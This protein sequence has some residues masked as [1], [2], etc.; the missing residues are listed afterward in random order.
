MNIVELLTEVDILWTRCRTFKFTH[1]A[2][3][4][5][6]AIVFSLLR[7]MS[8]LVV[9]FTTQWSLE[10]ELSAIATSSQSSKRATQ[11]IIPIGMFCGGDISLKSDPAFSFPQR[12][13][14]MPQKIES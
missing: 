6:A 4:L 12:L 2:S 1:R 11:T 9:T 10:R 7:K 13:L 3:S 5:F 14:Q 8:Q